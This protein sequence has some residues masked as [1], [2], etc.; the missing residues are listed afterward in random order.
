[1]LEDCVF[2]RNLLIIK[3]QLE[4]HGN[5]ILKQT[6]N[7]ELLHNFS[8]S[9]LKCSSCCFSCSPSGYKATHWIADKYCK[10]NAQDT[11]QIMEKYTSALPY[12]L[13]AKNKSDEIVYLGQLK[14][15]LGLQ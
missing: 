12:Q 4:I 9:C 11:A 13:F 15:N 10:S 1:M 2:Q 8:I 6:G 7:P 5:P 3:L 14:R